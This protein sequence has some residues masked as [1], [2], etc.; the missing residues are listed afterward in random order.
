[1]YIYVKSYKIDILLFVALFI[2]CSEKER[3]WKEELEK[4]KTK[5]ETELASY[6][7]TAEGQISRLHTTLSG[8]DMSGLHTTLCCW[9]WKNN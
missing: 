5:L 4:V 7:T 9:F 2:D 8:G 3:E 6:K 1:M